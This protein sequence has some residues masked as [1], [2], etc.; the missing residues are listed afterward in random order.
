MSN[1][2]DERKKN[3]EKNK[4]LIAEVKKQQSIYGWTYE[5]MKKKIGVPKNYKRLYVRCEG[6]Q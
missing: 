5:E 1:K 4:L 2:N 3:K 6:R